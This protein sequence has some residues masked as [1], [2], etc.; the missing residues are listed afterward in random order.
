M[1]L[2]LLGGKMTQKL[3]FKVCPENLNLFL[4]L[5]ELCLRKIYV[6]NIY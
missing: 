4:N 6:L 2:K 5:R 1:L 3:S